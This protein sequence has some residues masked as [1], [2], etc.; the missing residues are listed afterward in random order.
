MKFWKV[1]RLAHLQSYDA[2]ASYFLKK[3]PQ[4][5]QQLHRQA[6][7]PSVMAMLS[8]TWKLFNSVRAK[9]VFVIKE[10][11]TAEVKLALGQTVWTP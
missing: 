11:F 9:L 1:S 4:Q 8:S 3:K 6:S 5:P 10:Y 7:A 2:S